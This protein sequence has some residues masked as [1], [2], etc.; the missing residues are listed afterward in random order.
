MKKLYPLLIAVFSASLSFGQNWCGTDAHLE[1]QDAANPGLI[2]HLH[3]QMARVASGQAYS[4]GGDRA[5]PYLIPVVVHVIHAGGDDNISYDQI[6]SGIDQLN[7]DFNRLNADTIDTRNTAEAPFLPVAAD[8]QIS[9][10]LAKLDPNGDCTNGVERR[11]SPGVAVS[12]DDNCKDWDT[13]GLDAWYRNDYFNIWVVQTIESGGAG[14]TLGYAELPYWPPGSTFGVVIRSDYFGTIGTASGDRTLTHEVGHCLG[15]LHTFQGGCHSSDCTD[16]GDYMCDTPPVDE[17]H[18]SCSTTQNYCGIPAGDPYGFDAYDQFENYMSYSPCQNMFST[19]QMNQIHS[20]LDGMSM[21]IALTSA[22]N[23]VDAGVGLPPVL[24]AAEFSSD[25]QTICAGN[26]ISYT[27]MSYFNV[28][29]WTWTFEGGTPGT[30]TAEN[31]TIT[32]NTGGT[33]DVTLEVTD[34]SSTVSQTFTNYVTVLATPGAPLPYKEG[35]ESYTAIPDGNNFTV[36]NDDGGV[37]WDLLDDP[38]IAYGGDKC[39]WLDNF[40]EFGNSN[41]E[42]ISGTIDL[43][44]VD[45]TDDMVFYFYYAYVKRSASNSEAL[46]FYVSKDCGATWALRKNISGDN[47]SDST[48]AFP[49]EPATAANWNKVTVTNINDPYYVD[50]FRYK[51]V[52]ENDGG[53]NIYIDNIN[54]YPA[55]MTDLVEPDVLTHLS[56]Y[57]N[58]ASDQVSVELFSLDGQDYLIELYSTLGQKIATLYNGQFTKGFQTVNYSTAH[59]PKGVYVIKVATAGN[60]RSIKL[61]KE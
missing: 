26:S 30:S 40:G 8:L 3:E 55:S 28:T 52:F 10:E 36:Q 17:A 4:S 16:N 18:W 29:G 50:N 32:Y 23:L 35:F 34:G 7:E 15:L 14:V 39:V 53:N 44:G 5:A 6:L 1:E 13:G 47:L 48:Q 22:S 46:K 49:F 43:S 20:N 51:F 37:T 11:Y 58:P 31:P 57:P 59:L 41:D 33:Y 27:D 54:L 56:V 42:L 61:I 45:P 9:F 2:Q 60:L 12:A 21:Y 24:C 19:D 38:A 25:L